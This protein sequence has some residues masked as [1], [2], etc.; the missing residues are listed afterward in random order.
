MIGFAGILAAVL[1]GA[2]L[3]GLFALICA[4]WAFRVIVRRG[5]VR[6]DGK[7]YVISHVFENPTRRPPTE[8]YIPGERRKRW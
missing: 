2:V 8:K 1:G 3:G 4:G 5:W 7:M 6:I